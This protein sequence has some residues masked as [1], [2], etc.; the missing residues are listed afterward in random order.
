MGVDYWS[1]Y[2]IVNQWDAKMLKHNINQSILNECGGMINTDID[3]Y[4]IRTGSMFE[5]YYDAW[6]DMNIRVKDDLKQC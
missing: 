3:S 1:I 2:N 6:L 4:I 5:R